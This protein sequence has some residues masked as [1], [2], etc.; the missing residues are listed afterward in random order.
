[1]ITIEEIEFKA[2]NLTLDIAGMPHDGFGFPDYAAL[3]KA[4]VF[5]GVG[6]NTEFKRDDRLAIPGAV[7]AQAIG[8]VAGLL[9][10]GIEVGFMIKLEHRCIV[11]MEGFVYGEGKWPE[12]ITE[13]S[14]SRDDV[15]II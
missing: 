9:N 4:R 6:F 11:W 14:L 7:D 2:L 1:M 12:Y 15:G 3:V 13:Y 10:G 5:T 8:N